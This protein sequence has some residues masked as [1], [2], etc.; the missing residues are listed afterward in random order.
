M[1]VESTSTVSTVTGR[2]RIGVL[3]N[4]IQIRSVARLS[5]LPLVVLIKILEESEW[6][7]VLQLRKVRFK[8]SMLRISKVFTPPDL[9]SALRSLENSEHLVEFLSSL[10]CSICYISPAFAPRTTS[11]EVQLSRIRVPLLAFTGR[12][13]WAKRRR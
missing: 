10:L 1:T 5:D 6:R 11:L 4:G 3:M 8:T 12:R 2:F 13:N 7:D 9:H